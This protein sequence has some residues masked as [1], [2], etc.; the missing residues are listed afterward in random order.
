M[1]AVFGVRFAFEKSW[2]VSGPL[3]SL[4]EFVGSVYVTLS[5][6]KSPDAIDAATSGLLDVTVNVWGSVVPV[7]SRGSV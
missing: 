5:V 2:N 4:A 7:P 6:Q 1:L 3:K